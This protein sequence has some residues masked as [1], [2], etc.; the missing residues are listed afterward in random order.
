MLVGK[1]LGSHGHVKLVIFVTYMKN[2]KVEKME[3][4]CLLNQAMLGEN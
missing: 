4:V 3:V 2:V 1:S